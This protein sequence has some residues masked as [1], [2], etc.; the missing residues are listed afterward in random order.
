M[1]IR[2]SSIAWVTVGGS[3][4][5][6]SAETALN[7]IPSVRH[8]P[9]LRYIYR[10]TPFSLHQVVISSAASSAPVLYT[11]SVEVTRSRNVVDDYIII[12]VRNAAPRGWFRVTTPVRNAKPIT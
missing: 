4:V 3:V 6:T 5:A 1:C 2:D 10:V 12:D 7:Q 8:S 9:I 11:E